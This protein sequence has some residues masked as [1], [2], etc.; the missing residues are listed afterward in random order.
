MTAF[1]EQIKA[2][3]ADLNGRQLDLLDASTR[4]R[5][6]FHEEDAADQAMLTKHRLIER[7]GPNAYRATP[8]GKFVVE[9]VRGRLQ[10]YEA[11]SAAFPGHAIDGPT[12]GAIMG[13]LEGLAS[14][15][16]ELSLRVSARTTR[17]TIRY[18]GHDHTVTGDS[19]VA[20]MLEIAADRD[21][22][23]QA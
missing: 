12:A 13:F 5:I 20:C 8:R 15:G 16:R 19:L 22:K 18:M 10:E 7:V 1:Q 4:R 3:V 14:D 6:H 11:L 2:V 17:L 9:A 21:P 23:V